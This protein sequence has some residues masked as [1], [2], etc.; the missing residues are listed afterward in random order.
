MIRVVK[1]L[2]DRNPL[3]L[4]SDEPTPAIS[5]SRALSFRR[6]SDSFF[7]PSSRCCLPRNQ[8]AIQTADVPGRR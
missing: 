5:F 8:Y 2:V 4:G 3:V 1:H 7:P 6:A